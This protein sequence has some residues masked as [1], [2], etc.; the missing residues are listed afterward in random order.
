MVICLYFVIYYKAESFSASPSFILHRSPTFLPKSNKKA[1]N[2]S[3]SR[4]NNTIRG[5]TLIRI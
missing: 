3:L 4:T 1:L 5:A 2:R